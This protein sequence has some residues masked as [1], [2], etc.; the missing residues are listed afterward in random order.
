MITMEQVDE[1]R[2]RTNSSYEDA[3][4]YLER[5]NGNLLDAIIDFERT[6]T[7]RAGYHNA[8]HGPGPHGRVYQQDLGHGLSQLLQKGFDTRIYVE[9]DKSVLFSIPVI[10][11]L[12]LIPFWVIVVI[13]FVFFIMLGY[14]VTLRDS[15]N[16]MINAFYNNASGGRM[17]D[18][19]RQNNHNAGTGECGKNDRDKKDGY[20]EYTIE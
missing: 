20:K 4:Y 3:K 9:D 18:K 13:A 2:R 19:G 7:G 10:F 14:R 17:D 5:N 8:Y 15:K 1:F 6:K 12:F 11:L 16:R